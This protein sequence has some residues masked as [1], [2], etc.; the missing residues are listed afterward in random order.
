MLR[1]EPLRSRQCVVG[2]SAR[3]LAVRHPAAL[4]ERFA[5]PHACALSG[6]RL[7]LCS[8]RQS[9]SLRFGGHKRRSRLA[10]SRFIG[11][12]A[13]SGR[14]ELRVGAGTGSARAGSVGALRSQEVPYIGAQA[15]T[16]E[17]SATL[18]PNLSFERTAPAGCAGALRVV[19][20]RRCLPLNSNVSLPSTSP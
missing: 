2:C 9:Q 18:W 15:S 7:A 4:T 19:H 13:A 8:W 10:A 6:S 5:V 11:G 16:V 3:E 12:P 20:L 1:I 17:A 14:A